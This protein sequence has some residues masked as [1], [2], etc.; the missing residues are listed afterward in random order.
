MWV[1][2]YP[3]PVDRPTAP[4]QVVHVDGGSMVRSLG[5]LGV[6]TKAFAEM[7]ALD[8]DVLE[9]EPDDFENVGPDRSAA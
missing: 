8:R 3:P 6:R 5:F 9:L 7:A 4:V 2:R 1:R